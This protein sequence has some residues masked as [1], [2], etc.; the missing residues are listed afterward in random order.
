MLSERLLAMLSGFFGLLP[1]GFPAALALARLVA[2]LL[3]GVAPADP[4]SLGLAAATMG[5]VAAAFLPARRASG[6]DPMVAT[7]C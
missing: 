1:L 6:V 7:D 4:V 5:L 2:G 3:F